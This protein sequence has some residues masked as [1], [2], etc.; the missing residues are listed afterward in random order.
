VIPG[1]ND[2]HDPEASHAKYD[3]LVASLF[4]IL[5]SLMLALVVSRYTAQALRQAKT[6]I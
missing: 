5:V 6:T 1:L 2:A 4:L 3:I